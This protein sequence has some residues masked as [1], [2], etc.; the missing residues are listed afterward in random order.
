MSES[1]P[2]D[3]YRMM[4]CYI[5][6]DWFPYIIQPIR[7]GGALAEMLIEEFVQC[8]RLKTGYAEIDSEREDE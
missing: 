2:N 8:R 1:P 4:W 6:R 5:I 7:F 3:R